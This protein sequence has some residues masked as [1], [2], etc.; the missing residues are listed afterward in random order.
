[1]KRQWD[2]TSVCSCVPHTTRRAASYMNQ[3]ALIPHCVVAGIL[4]FVAEAPTVLHWSDEPPVRPDFGVANVLRVDMG[5][6]A[7][8]ACIVS[9]RW[10]NAICVQPVLEWGIEPQTETP[11]S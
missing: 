6:R 3:P 7:A 2:T 8:F 1:M 11:A 4:F 5:R 10:A 9:A